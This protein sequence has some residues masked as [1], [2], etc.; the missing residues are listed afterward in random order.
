MFFLKFPFKGLDMPG[1]T[2]L[3]VNVEGKGI[4]TH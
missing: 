3:E 4:T 1:A 2:A